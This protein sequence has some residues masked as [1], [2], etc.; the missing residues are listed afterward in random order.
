MTISKNNIFWFSA[1]TIRLFLISSG[2]L[3]ATKNNEMVFPVLLG[4]I[5]SA[6]NLAIA[7]VSIEKGLGKSLPQF[8]KAVIGGMGVRIILMLLMLIVLIVVFEVQK[9]I[10]ITSFLISYIIFLVAEVMY[11]KQRLQQ[12]IS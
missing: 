11:I 12:Q 4:I 1:G 3:L 9:N 2:V 6:I 5:L 7:Y 10:L 8:M